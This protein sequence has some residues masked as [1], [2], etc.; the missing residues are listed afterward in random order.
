MNIHLDKDVD[1]ELIGRLHKSTIYSCVIGSGMYG[2][3]D[4]RSDVDILHIYKTSDLELNSVLKS[5]HQLQYK[6]GGVDYIFVNI[7]AFIRNCLSGDSTI[8]FEVI[9]SEDILASELAFLYEMRKDF[10]N[11]KIMRSYLGFGRRDL[12]QINLANDERGKNKKIF[13]AYRCYKSCLDIYGGDFKSVMDSV[14]SYEMW[15]EVMKLNN[16]K[17]REEYKILIGKKIDD[18]RKEINIEYDKGNITSYMEPSSL[19]ILDYKIS[20]VMNG[21][22]DKMYFDNLLLFYKAEESGIEY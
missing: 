6:K 9:N 19:L 21:S 10:F 7:H 18:L 13:H 3:S 20:E 8:N 22:L 1:I 15:G 2:I 16:Y 14:E 17:E 4:E 5:H 11:Y 12:K